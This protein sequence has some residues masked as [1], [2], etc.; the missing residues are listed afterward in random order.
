M[1]LQLTKALRSLASIEPPLFRMHGRRTVTPA[2]SPN[3]MPQ[4]T[5]NTSPA[6]QKLCFAVRLP[7]AKLK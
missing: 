7:V 5:E 3:I 1:L 2:P 4:K 6:R